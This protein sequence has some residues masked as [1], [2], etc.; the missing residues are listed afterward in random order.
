MLRLFVRSA[1]IRWR[2]FCNT[3]TTSEDRD[4]CTSTIVMDDVDV[5]GLRSTGTAV[6]LSIRICRRRCGWLGGAGGTGGTRGL[7]QEWFDK[8]LAGTHIRSWCG[9]LRSALVPLDSNLIDVGGVLDR[10]SART[11]PDFVVSM[12]RKEACDDDP[13]DCTKYKTTNTRSDDDAERDVRMP[14]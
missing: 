13:D 8:V 11:A 7:G 6:G 3:S 10:I 12:A 5:G 2:K 14:W 9:T 1:D 4:R